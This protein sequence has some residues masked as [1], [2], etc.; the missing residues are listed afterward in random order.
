[1]QALEGHST[2]QYAGRIPAE[3]SKVP[4]D[5]SGR[6]TSE[7]D[8]RHLMVDLSPSGI[9]VYLGDLGTIEREYEDPS[10]YVRIDGQK[11]ILLAVEMREGSNIVAQRKL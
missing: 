2:V 7:D 5:A 11:T 8:I 4:L 3:K 9:P 1:V 6:F 10:E